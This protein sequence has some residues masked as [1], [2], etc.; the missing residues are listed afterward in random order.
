MSACTLMCEFY[1]LLGYNFSFSDIFLAAKKAGSG[2]G[3]IGQRQGSTDPHT[4]LKNGLN[5]K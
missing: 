4:A 3:S 5:F 2:S 1:C